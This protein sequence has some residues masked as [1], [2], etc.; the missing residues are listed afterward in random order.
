[1]GGYPEEL[2]LAEDTYF[3]LAMKKAGAK[4]HFEP[5]AVIYWRHGSSLKEF[6]KKRYT[7]ALWDGIA[8][9]IAGKMKLMLRVMVTLLLIAMSILIISVWPLLLLGLGVGL[10]GFMDRKKIANLG[11]ENV[12][13]KNAVLEISL[14]IILR[15]INDTVSLTGFINGLMRRIVHQLITPFQKKSRDRKSQ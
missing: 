12:R 8:G 1:V 5:K 13:T 3:D 11:L 9:I 2:R 4:F 15:I 14:T 10:L 6:I 7:Y